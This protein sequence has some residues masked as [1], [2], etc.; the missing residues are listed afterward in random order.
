MIEISGL[1]KKFKLSSEYN[2]K[3]SHTDPRERDGYFHSVEDVNL[4]CGEGEVLGLLGPNGAGKTTTLRMLSTALVPDEGT[5]TIAGKD[6]VKKP[7]LGR[8]AIGFLSGSTGLYGRLT[9]K[10]NV[11]YFA[12]LHGLK[13]R[14]L[15]ARCDELFQTLEMETFLDKRA[16]NLS[17]GMKQKTN[18]ARAVVHEPDVVVLDEPTT[19]LDIMTTQTVISFI[20]RLKEQGT[21]VIFSTHHLDEVA[22][23]CDRVSVIDKGYT[24]F[25]GT[26]EGFKQQGQS[27]EL[28]QA[29]LN[30]LTGEH[31][32]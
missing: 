17:T 26:V 4:R 29:F 10:E 3:K 1:K 23:L 24:C 2:K 21:P 13:G 5:I 32:V 18:I 8:K 11:E 28:N 12:K 6:I 30:L 9:A 16:E 19:G 7:L 15:Q 25:D 22:L 20:R 27:E 14:A 31:R